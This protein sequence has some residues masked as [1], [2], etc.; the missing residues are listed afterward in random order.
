[1]KFSRNGF[2]L[3]MGYISMIFGGVSVL[4]LVCML[5]VLIYVPSVVGPLPR[6]RMCSPTQQET[7][8]RRQ[9]SR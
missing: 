7:H 2:D 3:H 1:M 6:L 4:M 5:I 8:P 9:R